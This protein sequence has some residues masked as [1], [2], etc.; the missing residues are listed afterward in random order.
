[1]KIVAIIQARLDSS[2]LPGKVL[3]DLGGKVVM[4]WVI[5]AARAIPGVDEVVVATSDEAS[6]EKIVAFCNEYNCPSYR[7][8]K[9]DVLRRFAGAA[10]AY[11]ADIVL[12]ITADCPFLDPSICATLLQML[13]RGKYDYVSNCDLTS[14]PDG[15]D[16][17]VLTASVLQDAN[18]KAKI[19]SD[20]EHV[21]PYI[22]SRQ[23]EYSCGFLRSTLPDLN[24]QRWT[25][26]NMDDYKFLAGIAQKLGG[27]NLSGPP[28]HLQILDILDRNPELY[29]REHTPQRN[30]GFAKSLSAEK[31]Q[32]NGYK[33]SDLLLERAERVIPLGAQTFSKSK[34]Q[35][36][37][38]AAPL[39]LT[40][41]R[42]GQVWD[43]DGNCY[44]DLVS[45]LLPNVL[46]YCDPDVDASIIAQLNKGISFSLS[47][48][49]E[50]ELAERLV[51]LIPSAEMVRFGKNGTDATSAA[52]RLA[53]AF[54]GRD[55][56]IVLG[57]HG[58]QDWYIGSTTRHLGVPEAVRSLTHK[59]AFNNIDSLKDVF[60]K[61][62]DG[63]AAVMMEV[64]GVEEPKEGYLKE[65]QDLC[66]KHGAVLVFDE[67]I[68]GFRIHAGGAQAYYGVTP[69]L[70]AFG[71]A[72]GN[73]MPISA[74]V[75]RKDIMKKMEDIFYSGTFGG[76]ALSLAAS[77]AVIDKIDNEKVIDRLW[78]TGKKMLEIANRHIQHHGLQ[79]NI[80][81]KGLAPWKIFSFSD[82]AQAS[83]AELKTKFLTE[84]M[85]HGVLVAASHN[86]S[87]AHSEEDLQNIDY[88]YAQVLEKIADELNRG[89]LAAN[90][91]SPVLKPVFVV[92]N[93]A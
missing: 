42:G 76:E 74:V 87:Y 23:H 72:M 4:Q 6:D 46:G 86:V 12:R 31:Y 3:K 5:D 75:G 29:E 47:T 17:E 66:K 48:R 8:S 68:S 33:N 65:V 51:D 91:E 89:T 62:P 30:E 27:L 44:T 43:V 93:T 54:T 10:K 32:S 53:R 79:N 28:S 57:Y 21:T 1:M 64:M 36:P 88:A 84:M 63:I 19:P 90:L 24:T 14:W 15:L 77:I 92:R 38:N 78:D 71:K 81:L 80:Q 34:I 58:W 7:G 85:R 69:D 11:N 55:H 26:D 45:G 16:C 59:A 18:K 67:I 37:Q 70:S 60:E 41:G 35:F 39:F 61:H 22:R 25:L 2:R 82:H 20:R 49:L 13:V 56:V 52:I 73:G 9:A 83:G 50:S 40:H